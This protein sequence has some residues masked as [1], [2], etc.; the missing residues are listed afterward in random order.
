MATVNNRGQS[1]KKMPAFIAAFIMTIFVGIAI[2]ALGF[3][4]LFNINTVPVVTAD[5]ELAVTAVQEQPVNDNSAQI[6]QLQQTITQY[7][8]REQQYR[9]ELTQAADELSQTKAELT[10]YQNLVEALQNAGII[11]IRPDGRVMVGR[12]R[13][14]DSDD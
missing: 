7:Q 6:A 4:A 3:N 11:Q 12:G 13:L 14:S 2:L 9:Q 8:A 10:Q 5:Q 1:K